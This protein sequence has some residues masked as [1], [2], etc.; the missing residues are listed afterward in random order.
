[1]LKNKKNL[2]IKENK[3]TNKKAKKG[4]LCYLYNEKFLY[5]K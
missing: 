5:D 2:K 1:M 4:I 3:K